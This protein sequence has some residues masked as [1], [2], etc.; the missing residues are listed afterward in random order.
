MCDIDNP[1]YGKNGAAFVFAP[2]K[3]AE[4]NMVKVR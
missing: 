4:K 2:Q 1:M 3:G